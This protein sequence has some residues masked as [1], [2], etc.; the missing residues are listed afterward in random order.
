MYICLLF[1]NI[2]TLL[3]TSLNW[4]LFKCPQGA[5]LCTHY[6]QNGVCK[7]GPSCKFD[8]PMPT[9]SYSPSASSLADMPIAPF[10]VGSSTGTL[11]LSSSSSDLRPELI[12][13][14]PTRMPFQQ[15]CLLL[16]AL[17][18]VWFPRKVGPPLIF[19]SLV[20]LL[21]SLLEA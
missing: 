12:S 9:L 15:K 11:A 13:G 5:P 3:S 8:H 7:F 17:L 16:R 20:R 1:R 6:T 19:S 10:P 14:R 2:L 18:V 21:P 4:H